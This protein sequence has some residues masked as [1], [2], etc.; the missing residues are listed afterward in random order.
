[1]ALPFPWP[2]ATVTPFCV[3]RASA[4]ILGL[5]TMSEKKK[6]SSLSKR[7]PLSRGGKSYEGDIRL[8]RREF[9]KTFENVLSADKYSEIF[10]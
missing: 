1:M 7:S 9:G 2:P 4:G 5:P 6:R 8:L 10:S 3:H